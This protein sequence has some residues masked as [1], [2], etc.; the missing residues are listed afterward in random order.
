VSLSTRTLAIIIGLCVAT[1]GGYV[2]YLKWPKA[3]PAIVLQDTDGEA[4]DLQAMHEGKAKLV[5]VF[6]LPNCPISKFSLGLVR[7]QHEKL[8]DRFAFAGLFFGDQ[9]GAD[10]FAESEEIDFSVYGLRSAKDPFAVNELIQVVGSPHGSR[11]AVYGGTVVVV[12]SK[13]KIVLNL[14]KDEIRTLPKELA[15]LSD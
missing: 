13:G 5:L 12:N 14:A 9:R 11:T 7:E 4:V 3:I 6:L 15:E 1:A 2:I 8:A 10:Q